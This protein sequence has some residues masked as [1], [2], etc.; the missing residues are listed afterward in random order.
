[1]GFPFCF[2]FLPPSPPPRNGLRLQK[3]N[4]IRNLSEESFLLFS[5]SLVNAENL[6]GIERAEER[7][8]TEWQGETDD[9]RR[10]D[11]VHHGSVPTSVFPLLCRTSNPL[12]LKGQPWSRPPSL[13]LAR[14]QHNSSCLESQVTTNS[15]KRKTGKSPRSHPLLHRAL[16]VQYV[17]GCPFP[18]ELE[19]SVN[20]YKEA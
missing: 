16:T 19:H 13:L 18:L 4:N 1:M 10:A 6:L 7:P 2:F 14:K 8:R 20:Q 9:W 12:G 17:A 15:W 3:E 11:T 5:S